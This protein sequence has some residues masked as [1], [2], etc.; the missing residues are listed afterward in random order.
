MNR[1]PSL[2]SAKGICVDIETRDPDIKTKGPAVRRGGYIVG[3]GICT[4]D[5]KFKGYYPIA[6]E[7]GGNYPEHTVLA[8]LS[9]VLGRPGQPKLGA[10]ILYDLDYL[11]HAGVKVAG[12]FYDVQNAEPL[13][14]E[15]LFK[16][17]L[18]ALGQRH[19]GEGKR[20][21]KLKQI[22][23]AA[24][25]KGAVQEH[26]WRL[27]ASDV[28]E[29][30]MG[31][32]EL[33]IRV[34]NKQKRLLKKDGLWELFMLETRLIPLLLL[35]RQTGVRIDEEK[36]AT[37]IAATKA[38]LHG[39]DDQLYKL[40]GQIVN[41]WAPRS[42]VELFYKLGIPLPGNT[43]KGAPSF[44]KAFLADHEHPAVQL[45]TKAR[46]LDTFLTFIQKSIQDQIID[47]RIHCQFNQLR[48]DE[49]GAVSGRFSSSN[50]N[51]QQSPSRD[52]ILGPLCRSL[53]IPEEGCDWGKY[54]YSQVEFRI[55]AHYAQGPGSEALR[56]AYRANPKLDMHQW[57]AETA[58]V[59]R[60]VAK[61]TNFGRI[62]GMGDASTGERLGMSEGRRKEFLALYNAKLPFV[63][64]TL[65]SAARR[66]ESRGY[67]FTVL[68][69]R[70]RF[71]MWEPVD[72][73]LSRKISA[74]TDRD[75]VLALVEDAVK[76]ARVKKERSPNGGVKRAKGY[77]AINSVV[78]GSAADLMKQAM[79]DAYEAGVYNVL[80]PHL[81]VHDEMDQSV[82]R[83][84][85]GRKAFAELGTIMEQAIEFRVPLV[86]DGDIM[87]NW[88]EK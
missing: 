35:M 40:N 2:E 48:S 74:S 11:T 73:K 25:Y 13:L 12:P 10:N 9:D 26:I 75:A 30:V 51:L 77:K 80:P 31:D 68:K 53:F 67:V 21:G 72:W 70:R 57:C 7:G 58:G 56:E 47:G 82:P 66:A 52:P 83:D 34:F 62:Y 38:E 3:V 19:L 20:D 60:P 23:D 1:F 27:K 6:H 4:F 76:E 86:A 50:P 44:T 55:F 88:G 59:S 49:Y 29:Y 8:W 61:M 33:P 81:T 22:C 18:G 69:R 17:N 85:S 43:E 41:W 36:L 37:V 63:K 46:A 84:E 79:V 78:S 64:H 65:D 28:E 39:L 5:E 71:E 14:N 42:L 15:N 24:G 54:D 87:K 16:Y 45:V 32:V